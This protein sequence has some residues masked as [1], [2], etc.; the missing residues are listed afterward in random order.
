[1]P[2]KLLSTLRNSAVVFLFCSIVNFDLSF[3]K[4]VTVFEARR[5]LSMENNKQLPKD[6]FI[7]AGSVEGLKVGMIFKVNRRQSLYDPYKQKAPEELLI[8]VGELRVIHVQGDLSVA[9]LEDV[10]S[11]DQLPTLEADGIMVGDRVD[12][13]SGRMA[14]R[15]TAA[16]DVM[17]TPIVLEAPTGPTNQV[18]P[19][20][21]SADISS[22]APTSVQHSQPL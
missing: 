13:S 15:K 11:R 17:L 3:A 8:P 21:G 2:R 18:T 14:P 1:M 12:L 19:A 16:V 5:P 6:Y 22:T 4:D 9:R 7:N 20:M 10:Y